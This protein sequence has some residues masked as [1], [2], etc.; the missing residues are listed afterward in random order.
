MKAIRLETRHYTKTATEFTPKGT[1][2][3]HYALEGTAEELKAFEEAKGDKFSTVEEGAHKSKPIFFTSRTTLGVEA[4]VRMDK[5][6]NVNPVTSLEEDIARSEEK[7][8]ELANAK[9]QEIAMRKKAQLA[10]EFG[11]AV[12]F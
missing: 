3:L 4:E 1:L 9:K 6:G 2:M 8:A 12:Q 7:K 11:L 5:N 10:K